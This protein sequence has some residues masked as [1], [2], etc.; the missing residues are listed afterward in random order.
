M[1]FA[2]KFLIQLK[3]LFFRKQAAQCLDDELQFHLEQQVAENIAAGM[4]A[5]EARHAA[6][7]S[8]GDPAL[9]R[10]QAH[11][12]WNW[13]GL[14]SLLRDVRYGIRTLL[15]TPGFSL[16]SICVMALG[17][18]SVV[19]LFTIVQSVL[20][21]PFPFPHQ[22]QLVRIY[23]AKADHTYQDNV[24]AAGCYAQW[25]EQSHSL[26]SIAIA[27]QKRYNLSQGND[28][29][30]EVVQAQQVSWS[31]FPLLGVQP[32]LGRSFVATDDNSEAAAT[33]VLSWGLWKRRF[34]GANSILNKQIYLDGRP[35][36]VVGI[37]P[38]WF[39]YPE[40]TIQLWTPIYHERSAYMM[41]AVDAHSFSVFG[42]LRPGSTLAQAQEE[43]SRIQSNIRK[44]HPEGPVADAVNL[45][46][47][48]D[49][50]VH[51]VRTGLYALLGA[52]GCLL[53]IAC[54][55]IA[56][57]FV[58]RAAARRKETA[59]R[60]ALGGSR[61]NQIRQQIAES[62][63]LSIAGGLLGI[64][65]ALGALHWLMSTRDDIPRIHA[66]QIDASV[67]GVAIL[68]MLLCGLFSGVIPAF[69]SKDKN[70]LRF[71]QET[72]RGA[73]SGQSHTRLRHILLTAEVSLTVILLVGAGLLLKSYRQLRNIDIG[74][75]TH[76]LLTMEIHL[77]KA[78]YNTGERRVLFF[79]QLQK[80]LSTMPGLVSAGITTYAPAGGNREDN[81]F[82][83]T[84]FGPLPPGQVRDAITRFVTPDFF[85][86]LKLPLRKG[87]L[88][89]DSDRIG[90][91]QFVVVNQKLVDDYFPGVDPIGKHLRVDNLDTDKETFEI[92]G[93]VGNTLESIGG[94]I[95]PMAYY[96]L[97]L[98]GELSAV[99]VARTE[100]DPA[101]M[102]L[103]I[104]KEINKLDQKL[105]VANI[106]TV[107]E[108]IG[109]STREARF[110]AV[111]VMLFA[112]LSLILAAVGI[113]G[114][115]SYMAAQRQ[116]EIGIRIALGAQRAE[117]IRLM[118]RDGLRPAF[119]GLLIGIPASFAMTKWIQ[120]MLY[121]ASRFDPTILA[122]VGLI[123]FL[124][125]TTACALPAWSA[126]R[127]DPI[128][129]LRND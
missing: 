55:N 73:S 10:D 95:H 108:L 68:I 86:A 12:T 112:M 103:P 107:D 93:V 38:S 52:T 75:D 101:T 83:I 54:L 34:G 85:R 116:T 104:Q 99:V 115:L 78:E 3:M 127:L 121:E 15:R 98:G 109:R 44:Q 26:S 7:R 20:L 63:L 41:Q 105:P 113:F 46:T 88:L 31:Y 91:G 35:Y 123:L 87:R 18:G 29:F 40:N 14:E 30:P 25:K 128:Q 64:A 17:I 36:T 96:P 19:T 22:E 126:S 119:L 61:L 118:L 67:V 62:L 24:A 50:E 9:I 79:E 48:V 97:Y 120:S 32:T 76:K 6:M 11:E 66:V 102:A 37:M 47:L 57:L 16:V 100:A 77:P 111:L 69:A 124:V 72:S 13:N 92:V 21:R 23:E 94:K 4:D 42:R 114:V 2:H 74:Y 89:K 5:K 45:R 106:Y 125:A 129:A 53:F 56:N 71:L 84:E 28:Q 90:H 70:V 49:G 117:V 51:D 80:A 27:G 39:V 59:I 122:L 58:A 110:D 43:I 81:V 60:T 33:V 8:F 65:G 82:S 1:R